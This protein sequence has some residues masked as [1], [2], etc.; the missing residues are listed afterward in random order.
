MSEAAQHLLEKLNYV[1]TTQLRII[2]AQV[3]GKPIISTVFDQQEL[4]ELME[5]EQKIVRRLARLGFELDHELLR[6][7]QTGLYHFAEKKEGQ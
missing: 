4:T 7:E 2:D 3:E 1:V 6:D 5:N